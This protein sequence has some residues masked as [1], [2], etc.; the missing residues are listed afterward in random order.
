MREDYRAPDF[1]A[2]ESGQTQVP[3]GGIRPVIENPLTWVGRIVE[4]IFENDESS[5]CKVIGD[6][7]S[8]AKFINT[9]YSQHMGEISLVPGIDI[10][11]ITRLEGEL[12]IINLVDWQIAVQPFEG[13]GRKDS[14]EE[15]FVD[16][17]IQQPE[18]VQINFR[19][20]DASI[21]EDGDS[22]WSAHV[23]WIPTQGCISQTFSHLPGLFNG[24]CQ[25]VEGR[26]IKKLQLYIGR[27]GGGGRGGCLERRS[28]LAR[29]NRT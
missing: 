15:C 5:G 2:T 3:I 26:L 12:L 10:N 1:H 7:I 6:R 28:G 11:Q 16:Q 4:E 29:S 8:P 21:L 27:I 24:F 25:V 18:I 19:A 17:R 13:S 22:Q 20:K 9:G 23:G 14:F